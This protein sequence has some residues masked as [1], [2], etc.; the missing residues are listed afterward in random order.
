MTER[1]QNQPD[2]GQPPYCGKC[3]A[4]AQ[5]ACVVPKEQKP[6]PD[7]SV[8]GVC[9]I[10]LSPLRIDPSAKAAL[11]LIPYAT[12]EPYPLALNGVISG[13]QAQRGQIVRMH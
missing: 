13:L 8:G 2:P 7:G 6:A 3:G 5:S 11:F 4:P 12:L 1:R 9:S 10:C